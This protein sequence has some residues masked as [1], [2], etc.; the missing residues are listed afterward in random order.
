MKE[1]QIINRLFLEKNG[2][3]LEIVIRTPKRSDT[4]EAWKYLNKVIGET[5]FLSRVK[6]ITLKDEKK[7]LDGVMEKMKNKKC[8]Q[9]F[10]E[11]D[12]K[13]IAGCSVEKRGR[14]TSEHVG[15]YGIAILQAYTGIGLG[16]KLTSHVLDI[17]KKEM[18]IEIAK[19]SV[20]GKN[21]IAQGLYRKMGFRYAGKIP[22]GV[23]HGKIYMDD[24]MMYK[25]LKK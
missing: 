23:K 15:S 25:V 21:K 8:I 12:G 20:F 14:Q 10:A 18:K 9:L 13:I 2:K 17:T 16:T 1:G 22:N 7:W 5:K 6:P 24:I 11:H 3:M 19:L 4:Y